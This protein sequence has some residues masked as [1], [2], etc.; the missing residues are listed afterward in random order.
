MHYKTIALELIQDQPEL[1]E[2]LRSTKMLLTVMD[3]Y[4]I[5]LKADHE[6]R[7]EAIARRRPGSDPSQVAAEALEL[8]VQDLRDRL[9]SASAGDR[10]V[11][12]PLDEGTG[13]PRRRTSPE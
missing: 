6:A 3:V 2:E 9:H 5:E 12:P 13:R 11:P 7:K 8:A 4:A 1:Y 10:T